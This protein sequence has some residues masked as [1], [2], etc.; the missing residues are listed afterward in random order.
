MPNAIIQRPPLRWAFPCQVLRHLSLP[1]TAAHHPAPRH[2][3]RPPL[4]PL[5]H[6]G[7]HTPR[8]RPSSCRAVNRDA[9]APVPRQAR[10]SALAVR[11]LLRRV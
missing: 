5:S 8:W 9:V 4:C 11:L 2:T 10:G 7:K 6:P 1:L 3:V